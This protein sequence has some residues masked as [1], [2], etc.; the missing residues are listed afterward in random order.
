MKF[1]TAAIKNIEEILKELK[2]SE[3]GLSEEEATK[4]LKI[5][6]LNEI[7][8]KEV[9]LIDILFR[10]FKSPFFYLLFIASS[11]AF[12]IGEKIDG[13]LILIFLL[14]S[15]ILGFFQEAKAEKAVSL[16]KKYLSVKTRVLRD[17]VIKTIDKK[18]LV[19]GDI[20]LLEAGSIVPADLRILKVKDFLIDESILTGESVPVSKIPQHFEK[21]PKEIFEAKNIAFSG[22]SVIS[23]GAKGVVIGTG[24]ET[25]FG[26]ITKLVSGIT[27]ES[28]YE[29]D[30][31][32]FS[33]IILRIVVI[34]IT[35]VF[36]ANLIIKGITD[37]FVFLIFSIALIVGIIPEPLPVVVSF[38]FS[39]GALRLAKEKV[40]V[41]RLSAVEDLG[42][43]EVLCADKTGTL[44]EN[45][46]KLENIYSKDKTKCLL[47]GLFS[48]PY[49]NK[50]IPSSLS[51]FD[52]ALFEKAS[53]EI[54]EE[55]GKI[56]VISE[57]PFDPFRS[58]NSILLERN[59][60]RILIVRGAA[61][62]ILKLSSRFE[63]DFK[64]EEIK[65]G[66]EEEG[67]KGRRVLAV[68]YKEF[69]KDNFSENDERDLIFLGYFSFLD[70]LKKTAKESIQLARKLG[71]QIKIITGDS[72]E[73]AGAVA[74]E[75]G[76]IK[77][78][79]KV[80]LGETLNS[81]S[82]E[83]FE[84][85]CDE[86]V[87]FARISPQTKY[88][89]VKTLSKKYEVGFLGEG[90]N[91][92]PALKAAHLALAVD[93]ATDV[94]REVSD[95]I[96]LKEDLKVIINGIKE[97][98]NIFSNINKYIKRTISSNFGNFYSIA[99][100]SLAIPFL[101][102]LPTQILLVNL[103]SDF[104]LIAI[105]SDSVDVEELK[106]PKYYQL[107]R[108]IL[109]IFLLAIVSSIFDLIFF[110]L[111]KKVSPSLF[112]TLWFIMSIL[113]EIFLIFSIRTSRFFLKARFPGFP[114][115]II[116]LLTFFITIFLPF[117]NFGKTAFHFVAP[118]IFPLLIVLSLVFI[119]F[120]ISEIVKLIYFRYWYKSS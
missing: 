38:S 112:Q 22:T 80:I 104:P 71:L 55:L 3:R 106:K 57:I 54:R 114:L 95:I 119:Y 18:F 63:G 64:V 47:Y 51:P 49:V 30:L 16:L 118:P 52:L 77:D 23:G 102:I 21:E 41:K 5:Y 72:K 45:K 75:V 89:I 69:E 14:L 74:K 17:G 34:T 61:E 25:V 7:K 9:E 101:P 109:L 65:K 6:G 90:I 36:L 19:P 88:K 32:K 20:V 116:S 93:N 108:M 26:E 87:V 15:V 67:K 66:I 83:E 44:T 99:I 33:K 29:K 110:G 68:G 98:R 100:I 70:P 11:I 50:E 94:A 37:F 60:K 81:L 58:R 28:V 40:V 48:S 103:L 42:N 4:R 2:T 86:F 1:S 117:T 24:K 62:I 79:Q 39:R 92:A 115:F 105:A 97:G 46:L 111:F 84:K 107:N 53:L 82:E 35:L 76:L 31:L 120:I 113:T 43:I 12:L 56:K 85:A 10:Q 13:L 78:P 91:D 59:G 27:R 96:L 8:A 73:V